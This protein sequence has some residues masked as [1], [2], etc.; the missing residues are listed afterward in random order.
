MIICLKMKKMSKFISAF[1]IAGN[2]FCIPDVSAETLSTT[3]EVTVENLPDTTVINSEVIEEK[4]ISRF[5]AK[6]TRNEV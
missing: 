1:L 3:T 2:I 6:G 4:T 5:K